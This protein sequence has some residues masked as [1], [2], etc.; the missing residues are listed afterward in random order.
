M[1]VMIAVCSQRLPQPQVVEQRDVVGKPG[2]GSVRLG[3][4]QAL[5]ADHQRVDEREQADQQQ[6]RNIAGAMIRYLKCL[7]A[8]QA[9]TAWLSRREQ[10]EMRGRRVIAGH[11]SPKRRARPGS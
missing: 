7:S 9:Q 10:R 11:P 5:E 6:D 4:R 2:E 3:H 8:G 1:T